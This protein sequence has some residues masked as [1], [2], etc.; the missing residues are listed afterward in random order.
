MDTFGT[1]HFVLYRDRS[2]AIGCP[3]PEVIFYR[4]HNY[5]R[6]VLCWEVCPLSECMSFIGPGSGFYCTLYNILTLM[7]LILLM[8]NFGGRKK[9]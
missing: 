1:S 3:L 2:R 6:V 5:T 9:E 7:R 8:I 4:V